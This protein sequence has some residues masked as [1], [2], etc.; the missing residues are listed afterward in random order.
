MP[1]P[2]GVT[3]GP[4]FAP[5]TIS[6]TKPSTAGSNRQPKA[7][8]EESPQDGQCNVSSSLIKRPQYCNAGTPLRLYANFFELNVSKSVKLV[9]YSIEVIRQAPSVEI[10]NGGLRSQCIRLALQEAGFVRYRNRIVTDHQA[11]LYSVVQLPEELHTTNIQY[12]DEHSQT[13]N[14]NARSYVITLKEGRTFDISSLVPKIVSEDLTIGKES[15]SEILTALN[16]FL[17][18]FAQRQPTSITYLRDKCFHLGHHSSR[19]NLF[20]GLEAIPGFFSS[21]RPASDKLMVNVNPSRGAFYKVLRLDYLM[22]EWDEA[23]KDRG[24]WDAVELDALQAFLKGLRIKALHLN[25]KDGKGNPCPW[26]K[27]ISGLAQITDGQTPPTPGDKTNPPAQ[28]PSKTVSLPPVV[29]V[30]GANPSQ[31][32]FWHDKKNMYVSV[33]DHFKEEYPGYPPGGDLSRSLWCVVNVG[34]QERP[35]YLPAEACEVLPGQAYKK[36][37]SPQQT[38]EMIE[39]AVRRPFVNKKAIEQDGLRSVG[40][41]ATDNNKMIPTMWNMSRMEFETPAKDQHWTYVRIRDQNDPSIVEPKDKIADALQ[42]RLSDHGMSVSRYT[43]RDQKHHQI[44]FDSRPGALNEPL[45]MFLDQVS[46]RGVRFLLII[47]PD[48]DANRY[49]RL[50][51]LCDKTYGVK[52]VCVLAETDSVDKPKMSNLCLKVNLKM[53]GV[54][55]V[56][57][58][59]SL[60]FIEAGAT[61]VVSNRIYNARLPLLTASFLR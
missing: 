30:K 18:D 61:M 45:R 2:P 55:F 25:K 9:R 51:L 10:T 20:G 47:L 8:D 56:A 4:T 28:D 22:Y 27:R 26:I 21:V 29:D 53:G 35:I 5:A 54:N 23:W 15:R 32:Q 57:P 33:S 16:I 46:R 37:L 1:L 59:R 49:S 42:Q 19:H 58:A 36:K 6:S 43:A 52:N 38:T 44:E 39:V 24:S 40:L 12:R 7:S 11:N 3:Q 50:K 31:V 34:S 14:P 48:N 60:D 17:H 41:N 13:T